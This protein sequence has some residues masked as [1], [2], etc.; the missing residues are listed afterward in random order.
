M[1]YFHH[2]WELFDSFY[3]LLFFVAFL[4]TVL[5]INDVLKES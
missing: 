3:F 5:T 1:F 2:F 4:K